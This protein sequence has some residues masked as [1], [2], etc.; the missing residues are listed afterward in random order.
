MTFELLVNSYRT[1]SNLWIFNQSGIT[2]EVFRSLLIVLPSIWRWKV[3]FSCHEGL[4]SFQND[5]ISTQ[6]T[7]KSGRIQS[8][9]LCSTLSFLTAKFSILEFD[10]VAMK[11]STIFQSLPTS[12]I[13]GK[14]TPSYSRYWDSYHVISLC[15]I[16]NSSTFPAI[17]SSSWSLAPNTSAPP[18]RTSI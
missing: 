10:P 6:C 7:T 16:P 17:G 1:L 14:T 8:T 18:K 11:W 4:E 15:G 3:T 12:N 13:F 5:R 2:K 9:C